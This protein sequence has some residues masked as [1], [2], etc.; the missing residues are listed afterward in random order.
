MKKIAAM[1]LALALALSAA[2]KAMDRNYRE[3]DDVKWNFTK[4]LV[5][6]EGEVVARFEPTA[7]MKDVE[8]AIAALL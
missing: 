3:S 2:M 8:A 4:F 5:S 1:I 6:R 7:P